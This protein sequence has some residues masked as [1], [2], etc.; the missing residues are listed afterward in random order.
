MFSG[1]L[2]EWLH[3]A[4]E[5]ALGYMIAFGVR[6]GPA[7]KPWF[8]THGA[9]S[10]FWI[11]AQEIAGARTEYRNDSALV[12]GKLDRCEA[13]LDSCEKKIDALDQKL[14]A[15]DGELRLSIRQ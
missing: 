9:V 2:A 10:S 5:I 14:G 13:K 8:Q 4:P 3:K 12:K 7:E 11:I 1:L 15:R 6:V